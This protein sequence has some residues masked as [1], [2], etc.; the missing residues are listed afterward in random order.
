MYDLKCP[1][2]NSDQLFPHKSKKIREKIKMNFR[3]K[4]KIELQRNV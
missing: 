1:Y 3:Q 2:L 4:G